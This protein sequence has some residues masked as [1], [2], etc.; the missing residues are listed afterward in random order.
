[1]PLHLVYDTETTG[2]PLFREPSDDPRQPHIIQVAAGLFD[3]AGRC[4]R[5]FSAVV[6]PDDWE[7]PAEITRLTG[8]SQAAAEAYGIPEAKA[9]EGLL[10][11]WIIADARVAHN[12]AFDTRIVRI[13]LKRFPGICEPE[14]WSAGESVCTMRA[15]TPV[16]RLPPTEKMTAKGMSGFKQPTLAE[17]YRHLFGHDMSGAH[18]ALADMTACA[19]I[20]FALR[21]QRQA[22]E[23]A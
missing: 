14:T 18:N 13:A 12:A 2:L 10:K 6:K 17:A 9:V 1:M 7:I 4:V 23:A 19:D 16:C 20:Y 5:S 15:M 21:N 3:D 11:L 8:I 22:Q